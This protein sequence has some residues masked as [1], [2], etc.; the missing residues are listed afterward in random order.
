MTTEVAAKP[1]DCRACQ[2]TSS[3]GLI[4]IGGYLANIA[5][6]NN[7]FAGKYTISCLSF[8]NFLDFLCG[9]LVRLQQQVATVINFTWKDL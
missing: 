8:G 1:R 6:K 4:G 7:T 2:I 9:S 5:Y 3:A